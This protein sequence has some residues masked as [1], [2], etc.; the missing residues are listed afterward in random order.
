MLNDDA[1]YKKMSFLQ[2][3]CGAV[4][5]PFDCNFLNV[6]NILLDMYCN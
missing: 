2:N 5:S 4:P 6:S 1:L 3:S